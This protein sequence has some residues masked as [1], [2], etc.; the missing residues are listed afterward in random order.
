MPT[1][2]NSDEDFEKLIN[3]LK[4]VLK[5]GNTCESKP[6][7]TI[8]QHERVTSIRRA[9]FSPSETLSVRDAVGRVCA[10]PTVSCPPAVPIVVSGEKITED[11]VF[12]FE[13]YGIEKIAVLK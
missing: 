11:D 7:P 5:N 12:V 9:V 13:Y 1:P 4:G 2:E 10:S 8:S 6:S 3:A